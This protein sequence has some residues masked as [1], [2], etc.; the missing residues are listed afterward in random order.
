MRSCLDTTS[1]WLQDKA[2]AEET[3]IAANAAYYVVSNAYYAASYAYYAAYY[4][5]NAASNDHYAAFYAA[6][7]AYN[8]AK[9]YNKDLGYYLNILKTMI[10]DLSKLERLFYDLNKEEI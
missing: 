10:K 2:T 3:S 7:A 6:N 1:L 5:A 8:A 9:V 4:A